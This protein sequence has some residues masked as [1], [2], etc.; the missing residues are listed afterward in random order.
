[1]NIFL[2]EIRSNKRITIIWALALAIGSIAFLSMF[3]AFTKD[4]T[5]TQKILEN[6]PK[7]LRDALGLSLKDFFSV[8]GFYAYLFTFMTLGGAIQ[9]M[10]LGIGALSRE[11]SGKTVDFLLT[12]PVNRNKIITNKLLANLV[13]LILTNI[14][15]GFVALITAKIVTSGEFVPKTFMLITLTMFFIQLFFLA[16][17]MLFSVIMPKIKSVISVTLPTVFTFF[18]I[19]TLGAIIGNDKVK[20]I[21]PFKFFDSAY[22]I[23]HGNYEVKYLIIDFVFVFITILLSYM[24]YNKK[25]IRAVS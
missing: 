9:A 1:M 11:E 17:G 22:I 7:A 12:K 8:Y 3:P 24:I 2:E 18:I 20:F 10:N 16:L 19:G 5:A 25:D 6:F 13:L 15:F 23:S 14:I 4:V 21:S